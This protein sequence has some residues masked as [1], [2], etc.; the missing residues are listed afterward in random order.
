MMS[1]SDISVFVFYK[2]ASPKF[3]KVILFEINI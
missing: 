1:M 2:G 3:W